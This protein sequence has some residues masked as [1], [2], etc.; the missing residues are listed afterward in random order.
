MSVILCERAY[1]HERKACFGGKILSLIVILTSMR[2]AVFSQGQGNAGQ[3]ILRQVEPELEQLC[4]EKKFDKAVTLLEGLKNR[5]EVTGDPE[6][7]QKGV[8]GWAKAQAELGN[9]GKALE[10]LNLLRDDAEWLTA[11]DL[12]SDSS[13]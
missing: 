8:F 2:P 6:S 7:Y 5:P 11:E 10:Y 13:L 1:V 4:N 3:E 9:R 12:K